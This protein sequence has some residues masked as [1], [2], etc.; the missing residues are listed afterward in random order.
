VVS[1]CVQNRFFFAEVRGMFVKYIQS[2]KT[3]P[4]AGD[5][6]LLL[7]GEDEDVAA[8]RN[9]V[10]LGATT[11]EDTVIIKNLVKVCTNLLLQVFHSAML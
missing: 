2:R 10:M 3:R 11:K 1:R 5:E 8:E 9:K 4:E 7:H 6:P